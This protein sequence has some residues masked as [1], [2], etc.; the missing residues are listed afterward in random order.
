MNRV[1]P[2]TSTKPSQYTNRGKEVRSIDIYNVTI[3]AN[4]VLVEEEL[5][6]LPALLLKFCKIL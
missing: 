5:P 1:S 3:K 2:N 4:R 6:F